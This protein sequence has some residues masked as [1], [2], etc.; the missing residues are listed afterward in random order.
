[1]AEM[2]RHGHSNRKDAQEY[3]QKRR[4]RQGEM[5]GREGVGTKKGAK[6]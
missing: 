3:L 1:M 2:V 4:W 6:S 5:T